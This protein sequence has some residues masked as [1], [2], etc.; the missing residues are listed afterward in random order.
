MFVLLMVA[1]VVCQ[2][3]LPSHLKD[4][5]DV[6]KK[7]SASRY[8]F[9]LSPAVVSVNLL[10]LVEFMAICAGRPDVTNSLLLLI[11]F[12][13]IAVMYLFVAMF[14]DISS[15]AQTSAVNQPLVGMQE[16]HVLRLWGIVSPPAERPPAFRRLGGGMLSIHI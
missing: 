9:A 3:R 11:L 10:M 12:T 14:F 7:V 16:S 2:S 13:A 5:L 15:S 1:S 6:I 4:E 8:I